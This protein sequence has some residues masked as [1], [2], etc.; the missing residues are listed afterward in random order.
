MPEN[1]KRILGDGGQTAKGANWGQTGMR[2]N[3][4]TEEERQTDK[5]HKR[6]SALE[7]CLR[8]RTVGD[9][10]RAASA[11]GRMRMRG[12]TLAVTRKEMC[13]RKGRRDQEKRKRKKVY[14]CSN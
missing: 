2:T 12:N 1:T 10:R 11:Q 4:K 8:W 7:C 5:K 13:G 6:E 14:A 3:T 9:N